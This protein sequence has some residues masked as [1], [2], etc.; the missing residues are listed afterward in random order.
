MFSTKRR[1]QRIDPSSR[2][3]STS[4]KLR[5]YFAGVVVRS[6]KREHWEMLECWKKI[7]F[8]I[9]AIYIILSIH[10]NLRTKTTSESSNLQPLL[11]DRRQSEVDLCYKNSSQDNNDLYRQLFV[12]WRWSLR[13]KRKNDKELSMLKQLF[14]NSTILLPKQFSSQ[15]F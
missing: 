1:F 7:Y 12:I 14:Y 15:K 4:H 13:L 3:V 6:L 11:T 8:Y 10:L 2:S 9:L 5:Q